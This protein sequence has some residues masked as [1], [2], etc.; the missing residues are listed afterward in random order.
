M[1]Q[2]ILIAVDGSDT[3]YLALGHAVQLART[4]V[5]IVESLPHEVGHVLGMLLLYVR[6]A[7]SEEHDALKR[8][9]ESYRRYQ[10]ETPAFFRALLRGR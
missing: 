5:A 6:L 8:F 2:R 4:N 3:S 9:G 1:Y 10:A 7:R